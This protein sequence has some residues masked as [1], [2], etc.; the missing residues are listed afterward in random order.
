MPKIQTEV[1]GLISNG[2][3]ISSFPDTGEIVF[4]FPAMIDLFAW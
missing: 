4:L 3:F 1:S 2:Q